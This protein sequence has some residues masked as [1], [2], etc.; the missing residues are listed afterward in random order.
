MT[1]IRSAIYFVAMILTIILFGLPMSIF[2]WFMPFSWRSH[3]ANAWGMTNLWLMDKI[4][5]LKYQVEGIENLPTA[6]GAIIMAKHQSTWETISLRGLLPCN[7]AWVLKR[8]LMWLPIFGW[9]AALVEPIAIDRKAGR[10]AVVQLIRQ[11]MERL[12]KERL[13]IIFPE[14]T[15]TAPGE[16]R[17]YGIGGALVAEKSGKPLIP[18]AHNAG[19]FWRRRGLKK[20]PGTIQV[21]IG[22]QIETQGLTAA[23]I[24]ERVETWIE[25]TV[26]EMPSQP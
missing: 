19:I 22:S 10:K 9:A 8:E 1:T 13:L 23:E 15:R 21:V 26:A 25:G 14:G 24:N 18:I 17:R 5:G 4:C 20:Y 16:K 7:Q 11:S 12:E 6:G 2:G 3:T